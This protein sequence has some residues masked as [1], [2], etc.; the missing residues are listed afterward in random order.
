MLYLYSPFHTQTTSTISYELFPRDSLHRILY[1]ISPWVTNSYNIKSGEIMFWCSID[2]KSFPWG[3]SNQ[4][5]GFSVRK[6]AIAFFQQ[7]KVKPAHVPDCHKW[8]LI[9]SPAGSTPAHSVSLS[10]KHSC[11]VLVAN[12]DYELGSESIKETVNVC[13]SG[14]E[15]KTWPCFRVPWC[16][17]WKIKF[18]LEIIFR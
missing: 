2:P 9:L 1:Q 11:L 6:V 16:G 3:L 17:W 18:Y 12:K 7:N 13:I 14:R 5:S 10:E 4:L 8:Y 15:E